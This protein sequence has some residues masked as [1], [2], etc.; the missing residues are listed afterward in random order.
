MAVPAFAAT[1]GYRLDIAGARLPWDLR[2]PPTAKI[3][4]DHLTKLATIV[5]SLAEHW[6]SSV[7]VEQPH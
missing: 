2:V 1:A 6:G 5:A 3:G 7:H 4:E